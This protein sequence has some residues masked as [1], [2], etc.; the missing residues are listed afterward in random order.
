MSNKNK[1]EPLFEVAIRISREPLPPYW[2]I[3][4]CCL[5]AVQA[6]KITG[7]LKSAGNLT[8]ITN[9]KNNSL[10]LTNVP[11]RYIL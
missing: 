5:S 9:Q 6:I 7:K 8:L 11:K 3:T 4:Q 10:M 2:K 1:I